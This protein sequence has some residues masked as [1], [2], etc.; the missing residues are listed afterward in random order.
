MSDRVLVDVTDGVA[1]VRLNR[2]DKINALDPAM[3]EA[4]N[5]AGRRLADDPHVR[6]IVLSGRGPGV[7]CRARLRVVP[8]HGR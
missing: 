6:A 2:P 7:L 8:G 3:F 5:D 4:L 1:D